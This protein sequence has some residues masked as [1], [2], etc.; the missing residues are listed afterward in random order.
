MPQEEYWYLGRRQPLVRCP[1]YDVG[2][3]VRRVAVEGV[4]R[5][6]HGTV[7]YEN[8]RCQGRTGRNGDGPQC[9]HSVAPGRRRYC[10]K[11]AG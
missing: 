8:G 10:N 6:V 7:I 9:T 3:E 1:P 2:Y 11:H 4:P 5:R